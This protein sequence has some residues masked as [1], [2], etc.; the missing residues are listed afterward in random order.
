M[1]KRSPNKFERRERDFYVTPMPATLP[2]IPHL[3]GVRFFAEPCCGSGDL[4]RHLESFGLQCVWQGDIRT[5]QDALAVDSYGGAPVNITNPP[6]TRTV[7]H[8]LIVH[9]QRIAPTWLLLESDWAQTKQ[10]A[11]FMVSC[12]DIVAIGRVKWIE[13]SPHTGKDNYAWY[14]FD[15]RHSSGPV[16]SRV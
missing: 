2:L 6:F 14:R 3:R 4:I 15:A 7:L 16:I 10:A 12:S 9:F 13:G 1:G 5:G 11:P 8:R